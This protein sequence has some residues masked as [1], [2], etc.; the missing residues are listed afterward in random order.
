MYLFMG[1]VGFQSFVDGIYYYPMISMEHVIPVG[2]KAT[3]PKTVTAK[4]TLKVMTS[5]RTKT[6]VVATEDVAVEV[7][8]VAVEAVDVEEEE[9][10]VIEINP[11]SS[12][13]TVTRWAIIQKTALTRCSA[14]TAKRMKDTEQSTAPSRRLKIHR[15]QRTLQNLKL[16][17]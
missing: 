14:T 5:N 12:V 16:L 3:K 11:E 4:R 15:Q 9:V 7:A 13:S 1:F 8:A 6:K 10:E 2:R 17:K